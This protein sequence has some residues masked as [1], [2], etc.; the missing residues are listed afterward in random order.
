MFEDVVSYFLSKYLGQYVEN[1]NR[2]AIRVSLW[3]G[4]IELED[5]VLLYINSRLLNLMLLMT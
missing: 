1:I 5:L 3:K 2:E 4:D